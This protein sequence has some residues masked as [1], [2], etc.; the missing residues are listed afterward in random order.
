MSELT[1]VAP[2]ISTNDNY[3]TIGEWVV[4]SG[5]KVSK[6]D[7]IA[8]LETTKKTESLLA[9][10]DGYVFYNIEEGEDVTVGD[11]LCIL[12]DDASFE[13]K[14]EEN[15]LEEYNITKKA[16]ELILKHNIDISKFNKDEIIREKDVLDILE[17]GFKVT[18]SKANDILIVGG[19]G[20][21]K[22]YIDLIRLNK[23]YNVAGIIDQPSMIGKEI[24][25]VPV[26]G[27]DDD[28][29]RLRAEG[30]MTAI[31]AIGSIGAD[32]KAKSFNLRKMVTK[33]I[34]DAGFFMPTL[35]HPSAQIAPSAQLGEGV[36]V[37]ENAVIGPD[38]M[39]GDDALI[40]TGVIVSHDCIIG[41]HCRI[42]PGAVLAGDVK[43][44]ENA[45]VGMGTTVYLGVS[46]GR[47]AIISNGKNI[48]GNVGEYE[49]VQ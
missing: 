3:V 10:E 19:G 21:C 1:V 32:N 44:G 25:G 30:Y 17:G 47:N 41:N 20:L 6:D 26:I 5:D 28:L 45:L 9:P 8:V 42:S 18:R 49:V 12:T 29:P 31:N 38:A 13:F 24:L 11:M 36:V 15:P 39:I 22:M 34:K 48:F 2:R 14:K 7:E 33:K 27:T 43:V 4:K 16:K 37:M 35:I 46:I 23:A 40:N